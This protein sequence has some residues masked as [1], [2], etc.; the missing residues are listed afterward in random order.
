M[1]ISQ[2]VKVPYTRL[3]VLK[4]VVEFLL[5]SYGQDIVSFSNSV[6][7]V[8]FKLFLEDLALVIYV[9]RTNII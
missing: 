6:N 5:T 2:F 9:R 1:K 4:I 7:Y 3:G 8:I